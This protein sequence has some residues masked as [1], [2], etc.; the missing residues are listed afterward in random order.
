MYIL[1]KGLVIFQDEEEGENGWW[2]FG[3]GFRHR[4]SA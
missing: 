2:G 4:S 3:W 1:G